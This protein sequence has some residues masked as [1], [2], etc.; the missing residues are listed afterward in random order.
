MESD[1]RLVDMKTRSRSGGERSRSKLIELS[2]DGLRILTD[3]RNIGGYYSIC[4]MK[5]YD[6]VLDRLSPTDIVV[7]G[8]ANIGVFSLLAARRAGLVYAVE[9]NPNNFDLLSQNLLLNRAT[10]V[11]PIQAA[12]SDRVGTAYFRGEGEAGRLATGGIEVATTTIDAISSCNATCIKLDVEGSAT[13]AMRGIS[14]L[15]RVH[16]ICFEAEQDQL[17]SLRKEFGPLGVDVGS[18][19]TLSRSLLNQGY[20][21]TSFN[22]TGIKVRYILSLDFLRAEA[23]TRFRALRTFITSLT[24]DRKN[25]FYPPSLEDPLINTYYFCR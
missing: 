4:F 7:D 12:L 25:L 22:E 3:A 19:E 20:R 8:G 23:K 9:P 17:E 18:Y 15:Q 24:R 1:G 13:L 11:V 2:F 16:T 21:V 5:A 14:S 10:N 6:P